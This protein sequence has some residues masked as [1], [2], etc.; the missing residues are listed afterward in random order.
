MRAGVWN[1]GLAPVFCAGAGKGCPLVLR[2]IL[3]RI[4]LMISKLRT[5][6]LA[7]ALVTGASG[8]ALAQGCPP[9]YYYDGAYCRPGAGGV[10]GGAANAAGAIVGG[11]ANTAGAIVGGTVGAVTGAPYYGSPY[12]APG[13]APACPAGYYMSQGGCYPRQ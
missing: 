7:A 4:Y 5:M 3:E 9:G 12:P 2:A 10:V 6:A 8:M 11:A 13:Y 1:V